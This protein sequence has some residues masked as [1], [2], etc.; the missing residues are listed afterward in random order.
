MLLKLVTGL[1]AE[2]K[3]VLSTPHFKTKQKQFWAGF[4][5]LWDL[6]RVD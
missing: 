4:S 3:G 1:M 2:E 6:L 5:S